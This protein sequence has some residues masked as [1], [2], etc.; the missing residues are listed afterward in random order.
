MA[1]ES[2]FQQQNDLVLSAFVAPRLSIARF[3]VRI[4][5]PRSVPTLDDAS[6]REGGG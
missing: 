5:A 4:Q 1:P 6:K 2:R 3:Q